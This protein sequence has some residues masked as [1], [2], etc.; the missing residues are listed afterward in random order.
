MKSN[1]NTSKWFKNQYL[2][3][4]MSDEEIQT[5]KRYEELTDDDKLKLAKI[6]AMMDRERALREEDDDINEMDA[7]MHIE[8]LMDAAEM[9]YDA[10]MDVDEILGMIEQHLGLKMGDY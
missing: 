4:G 8:K 7:P 1:F 2:Y 9:A 3:E 6:Q 5:I 10:G